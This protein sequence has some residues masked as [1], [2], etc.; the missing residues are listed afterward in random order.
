[1]MKKIAIAFGA[2]LLL[3]SLNFPLLAKQDF[4]NTNVQFLPDSF[5]FDSLNVRFA[6]NWPFGNPY[7]MAYDSVRNLAFLGSG[8][9]VYIIDI[10]DPSNPVKLSESL[11]SREFILWELFYDESTQ[12]LYVGVARWFEIWDV[13]N[14]SAP[15]KLSHFFLSGPDCD[16]GSICVSGDYAYCVD[17]Y[18]FAIVDVSM[19]TNP[20]IVAELP[21]GGD[22]IAVKDSFAYIIQ[23]EAVGFHVIDISDP[24]NPEEVSFL[25][26]TGWDIAIFGDRAY[27]SSWLGLKF[28]IVDI[29]DPYNPYFC[30]YFDSPYD[31]YHAHVV[32]TIAYL[33]TDIGLRAVNI[34]D[35]MN[36]QEV[37]YV[38]SRGRDIFVIDTVVV[39]ADRDI[40]LRTFNVSNL[41]S[42][43]E[44]GRFITPGKTFNSQVSGSFAY[45]A[46]QKG[47]WIIDVS[48]PMNSVE[49]SRCYT[50]CEIFDVRISGSYAFA[51]DRDSG[52][53]VFD[54]SDP[55]NPY[56][57]SILTLPGENYPYPN[58]LDI[59]GQYA[60][61]ADGYDWLR[62]IDISNPSFP[63]EVSQCTII[64]TANIDVEVSGHYAYVI[65]DYHFFTVVDISN[66]SNP[67]TTAI[68]CELYEPSDICVSGGYAFV[69]DTIPGT[70]SGVH[71][72]DISDPY[73]PFKVY[74]GHCWAMGIDIS[75]LYA[76]VN[77]RNAMLLVLNIS[78]PTNPT[79]CG[80]YKSFNY[81]FDFYGLCALGTYAYAS[82]DCGLQ[83]YQFYGAGVEEEPEKPL[84][85]RASLKLLQ[86]PVRGNSIQLCL[87]TTTLY[88]YDIGLYN[89]LGQEVKSFNLKNLSMGKNHIDLSIDKIPNGVYFL[90]VKNNFNISP[91][92][93]VILK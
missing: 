85:L 73:N 64:G 63:Y 83:I 29:S 91:Q 7:N 70:S 69:T 17:N 20:Q 86:N 31:V 15:T 49:A 59:S 26:Q 89:V 51:T 58:G 21:L 56:I 32:D 87:T 33:A 75:G 77:V 53:I 1:M 93:V 79:V 88:N 9:G 82:S 4:G 57:A 12:R 48:D 71:I 76:Y 28:R 35:P 39:V 11:H 60:Y 6:G 65:S 92:K 38:F 22:G 41:P 8:A 84:P 80:R 45:V 67:E 78:E 25:G 81:N 23:I 74:F 30:G 68:L 40:G 13:S 44:M 72:F 10:S 18:L 90:K 52:L 66:P 47:L 50:P 34:A 3:I 42:L 46:N 5:Y 61:V 62:I 43:E 19:P 37:S 55:L 16:D 27:I 2:F 24:Q 54:I 36:P 14:P